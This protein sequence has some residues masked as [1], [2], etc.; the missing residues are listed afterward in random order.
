MSLV[1]FHGDTKKIV[2]ESGVTSIDAGID[3][4]SDWKEW[5][6]LSDNAKWL[7]AFR[8]FGGDETSI[9][10]YAPKYYFLI[11]GWKVVAVDMEVVIQTN[12]Y[13]DDGLSP[14]EVYN[15]AVSIRNSDVPVI[16]SELEQ[17][18][19]YGDRVYYDETS[20]YIGT[21]YPIGTIAQPINNPI[22]AALIAEQY[23]ISDI[24]CLSSVYMDG[25]SGISWDTWEIYADKPNLTFS[26]VSA[27]TFSNMLFDGFI[28]DVDLSGGTNIIRNSIIDNVY[29]FDGIIKDSQILHLIEVSKNGNIVLSNCF[30]GVAGGG[31]PVFDMKAGFPASL[32]LRAYSGGIELRNCDMPDDVTTLELIAG[33]VK[34]M[35]SCSD[36]YIDIRGVGYLTDNSSGSSVKTLGFIDSFENYI[37]ESK[38]LNEQLAY[39]GKL[40][41]DH[42]LG[43]TGTTYPNGT[44]AKPVKDLDELY[45]LSVDFNIHEIHSLSDFIVSGYTG[46]TILF[47][48]YTIVGEHIHSVFEMHS[49]LVSKH[50]QITN[51]TVS[52]SDFVGHHNDFNNCSIIDTTGLSGHIENCILDGYIGVQ[53]NLTVIDSQP[54]VA[55]GYPEIHLIDEDSKVSFRGYNGSVKIVEMESIN[56]SV[57]IDLNSGRI[58][59][60][61]GCT[62]GVI[63]IRG[64]GYVDDQ[65]GPDCVVRRD[66]QLQASPGEYNDEIVIDVINGQS[67]I[68]FPVGKG[69]TPV[70]NLA[71]ALTLLS[72]YKISKIRIVGTLDVSGGEDI[73][74]IAFTAERSTGNYLS[75]TSAITNNTYVDNLTCLNI[76][77]NGTIRYTTSVLVNITDFDGGAKDCLLISN[78]NV[79]GN[80]SNYFTNCDRYVTDITNFCEIDISDKKINIIR[81]RGNYKITN[82][83]SVNTTAID[84]V[85]GSLVVDS[86]CVSGTIAVGGLVDIID[87]SGSGCNVIQRALSNDSISDVVW[88]EMLSEHQLTG[89]TG[90]ALNNV[91]AGSDPTQ[92]A[93]AVWNQTISGETAEDLLSIINTNVESISA[94]TL[95]LSEDI[96][97]ILG[98]SQENYRLFDQI[99]DANDSLLSSTIRIYRTAAECDADTNPI[100]T[101][102]MS[103]GYDTAGRMMEYKV[104]EI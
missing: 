24:H 102:S 85:A 53:G 86:T 4:Y 7:A 18:L 10:Q 27:Q 51:F 96:E 72:T 20:P 103:A 48:D 78:F 11:N 22:D 42:I 95:K 62:N 1:T 74:N 76:V 50:L 101:Y 91:S 54:S 44:I 47:D 67:G 60:T 13:S 87:N 55:G 79:V 57:S 90:Y 25:Y 70:N 104:I 99:Y 34:L 3:L 31:T 65:S 37:E 64:V 58:L 36:G 94:T 33:Q 21:E 40:Y 84:L 35:P 52:N 39:R 93:N 19:D 75:I 15:S 77:Q 61:S 66:G 71:D 80:G 28:M 88:D 69:E 29:N 46:T 38:D 81:G 32:S 5:I 49:G 59:I 45:Q 8:T 2:I 41:Y 63:D 9:S 14:V 12:L 17:R 26:P 73:S 97:R 100:T 16:K 23:N 30:S 92:I 89:S 68:L 83:T 43:V 6:M 82:K 98:L 56:N